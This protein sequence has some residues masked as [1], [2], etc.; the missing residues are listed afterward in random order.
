M[1][2]QRIVWR[3]VC[4]SNLGLGVMAGVRHADAFS[5]RQPAPR[6]PRRQ[7]ASW[8]EHYTIRARSFERYAKG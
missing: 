4:T 5:E 6:R 7:A 1:S 8:L 3:D 2:A